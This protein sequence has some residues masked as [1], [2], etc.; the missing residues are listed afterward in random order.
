MHTHSAH[1][2]SARTPHILIS[3]NPLFV[4]H[5]EP[6]GGEQP[7]LLDD[8]SSGAARAR[9]A[10][11][12]IDGSAPRECAFE[13]RTEVNHDCPGSTAAATLRRRL[14]EDFARQECLLS[15]G[16]DG[17]RGFGSVDDDERDAVLFH[18]PA[19]HSEAEALCRLVGVSEAGD[20]VDGLEFTGGGS[21][22]QLAEERFA[23]HR[24]GAG[25]REQFAHSV[26]EESAKHGVVEKPYHF[27]GR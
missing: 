19:E 8:P 26:T 21:T 4:R 6:S 17:S 10:E 23:W 12:E 18:E 22:V 13:F 11:F 9:L 2:R 16:S 1:T 25:D 27:A 20:A 15:G 24:E 5:L 3:Q 7:E 14:V